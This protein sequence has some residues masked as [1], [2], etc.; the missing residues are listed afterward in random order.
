MSKL[1]ANAANAG[2]WTVMTLGAEPTA[3]ATGGDASTIT[4]SF[5]TNSDDQPID[6][7][8]SPTA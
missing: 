8:G 7:G 5:D 1:T 4:A 2:T 3:L 6:G